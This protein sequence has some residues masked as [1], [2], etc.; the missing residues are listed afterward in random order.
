MDF[1]LN[2]MWGAI[3]SEVMSKPILEQIK[4][5][6]GEGM[7]SFLADVGGVM[8]DVGG[9]AEGVAATAG[10]VLDAVGSLPGGT[11]LTNP[12]AEGMKSLENDIV[13]EDQQAARGG[14]QPGRPDRRRAA[15]G[16]SARTCSGRATGRRSS[17]C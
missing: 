9:V 2:E 1:A 5:A 6:G 17:W 3:D 12:I 8:E 10:N 13:G 4:E 16:D 15:R 11:F 14:Q 7:D